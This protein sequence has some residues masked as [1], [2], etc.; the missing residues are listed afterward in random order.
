MLA[1]SGRGSLAAAPVDLSGLVRGA[2]RLLESSLSKTAVIQTELPEDLPLVRA[3]AA[4]VRQ[5]IVALAT[6]AS[7]ALGEDAG[8]V[9]IR[10]GA[11]HGDRAYL[12]DTYPVGYGLPEGRYVFVE[13]SDTG[14]GMDA[15][16][17][18]KAFE[19]FFTTKFTGRGLGLAAT[20]GIVRAH[21]GAIRLASEPEVGTTFTVLFPALEGVEAEEPPP[22]SPHAGKTCGGGTIL[23][24]DD[25]EM[26]R[27]LGATVLTKAGYEVV[28]AEDGHQAVAQFKAHADDIVAVLLDLTMPLKGG[29]QVFR[30]IHP[31]RPDVPIILTSGYAEEDA[32]GQLAGL[33]I[34]G[35]LQKPYRPSELVSKLHRVLEQNTST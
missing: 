2:V 34:A 30:E 32:L 22:A 9:T 31:L 5:A 3:D 6:N 26:L 17:K 24:A 33:P 29:E 35:F 11:V 1:Y 28:V 8:L 13:V 21:C 10:T 19:P 27:T 16:T 4:Q 12:W 14:C 7:E 15:E 25:E 18:A 23:V 20:L